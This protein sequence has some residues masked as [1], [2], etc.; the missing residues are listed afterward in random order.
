MLRT[1]HQQYRSVRAGLIKIHKTFLPAGAEFV[2]FLLNNILVETGLKPVSTKLYLCVNKKG[3][4]SCPFLLNLVS[5]HLH[6][7][8]VP[9]QTR[10]W[11][12]FGV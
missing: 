2:I 8:T 7:V 3:Q 11:F 9:V 6:T 1:L 5:L 10:K 12:L 4:D